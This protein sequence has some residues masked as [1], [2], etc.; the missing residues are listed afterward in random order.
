MS[1]I[2]KTL[3]CVILFISLGCRSVDPSSEA[4]SAYPPIPPDTAE[5]D[6][7]GMVVREQPAPRGQIIHRNG[8]YKFFCSLDDMMIYLEAPSPH[9]SVS[10]AFVEVLPENHDPNE[11]DIAPFPW[12]EAS[13]AGFVVGVPRKGV[14]GVPVLAYDSGETAARVAERF[15][16]S[17]LDWNNLRKERRKRAEGER[18]Q[19]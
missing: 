1:L 17:M 2:A 14:M 5:C 18:H 16:A 4:A 11:M 19:R 12:L 9:G 13:R 15:K 8:T 7:C 3:G 6:A 10:G